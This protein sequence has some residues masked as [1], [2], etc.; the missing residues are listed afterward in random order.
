[1]LRLGKRF[2]KNLNTQFPFR[3][4]SGINRLV[5][6]TAAIAIVSSL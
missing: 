1:M 5:Q 3:K 4:N 2:V 6:I